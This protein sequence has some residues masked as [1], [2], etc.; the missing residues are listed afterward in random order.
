MQDHELSKD[1]DADGDDHSKSEQHR[2]SV[3]NEIMEVA[4]SMVDECQSA[5]ANLVPD[6]KSVQCNL[7]FYSIL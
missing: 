3:G 1:T 2:Q 4:N 5:M 6:V 7:T